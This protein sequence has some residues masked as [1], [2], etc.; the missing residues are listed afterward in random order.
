[1]GRHAY[2]GYGRGSKG[3]GRGHASW[4]VGR[5]W[6]N[7]VDAKGLRSRKVWT[8]DTSASLKRSELPVAEHE[9]AILRAISNRR[10]I[11]C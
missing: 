7:S 4:S 5:T 11:V 2:N 6:K 10:A 8:R 9:S 3:G 1:M